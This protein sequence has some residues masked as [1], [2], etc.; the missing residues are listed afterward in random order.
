MPGAGC[1]RCW[2][3]GGA[4]CT[5]ARAHTRAHTHA[6]CIHT[7]AHARTHTHTHIHTSALPIIATRNKTARKGAM[8]VSLVSRGQLFAM[9]IIIILE[10]AVGGAVMTHAESR[11]TTTVKRKKL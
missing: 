1:T 10:I 4:R 5:H 7:R 3:F 2:A 11:I 9:F 8:G 6:R